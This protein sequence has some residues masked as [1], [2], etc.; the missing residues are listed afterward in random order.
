MEIGFIAVLAGVVALWAA[1]MRVREAAIA[2]V[3]RAC[4]R[5]ELQLLDETV[6]LERMRPVRDHDGR[7][8]WRRV[9]R[10]EFTRRSERRHEGTVELIG[11]RLVALNLE[12]DGYNLHEERTTDSEG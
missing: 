1:G 3:R 2:V 12:M 7:M 10:F 8:R 11:P 4:R 5:D 9:Y 6:L